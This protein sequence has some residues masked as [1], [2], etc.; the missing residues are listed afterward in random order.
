MPAITLDQIKAATNDELL[1]LVDRRH[2]QYAEMKD[3]WTFLEETYRGGREWFE[4][5]LWKYR[6]EGA[7]EFR[8][9][10]KRAYRYPHTREV[11][12]LVNK[13]VLKGD[14]VRSTEAPDELKRFWKSATLMRRPVATLMDTISRKASTFG[15]IYI[16]VDNNFPAGIATKAEQAASRGRVYSYVISPLDALDFAF[17]EDGKLSWFLN[18]E[19]HRDDASPLTGGDTTVRYRLWAPDFWATIEV[20]GGQGQ[21]RKAFI[22]KS[23]ENELGE[24]PIIIHDHNPSE[25][26]YSSPALIEDTAYLDRAAANYLS[27]LDAIIQDQTFS[28]LVIPHQGLLED[29]N[30]ETGKPSTVKQLIAMGTKRVFAYNAEG[31]AAPSF[32]SPDVKQAD[33]IMAAISKIIDEIYHSIGMA[34]ERT[35]QDN[36]VGIDNSSGVAKA[37][38]FERLNAMLVAKALGLALAENEISRLVMGWNGT[39]KAVED[40][41]EYVSYPATF[42]VRNLADEMDNSQK[43]AVMGAPTELRRL[44]MKKLVEKMYPQLPAAD[45]EKIVEDIEDTWLELVPTTMVEEGAR[46]A[47]PKP[48]RLPGQ[49]GSQGQNNKGSVKADDKAAVVK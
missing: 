37:Y 28:Q 24:I 3:H 44:Q 41:E 5:N 19:V 14:I 8:D 29:G 49:K 47:A 22:A 38:D 6:K 45:R 31:G 15:R 33:L 16:V 40:A 27:C 32:I 23:G 36:S 46:P 1:K 35:K 4:R 34:G 17:D 20:S 48:G 42:D 43:L 10:K 12:N 39:R 25:E 7:G 13:Y 18:S 26:L 2:P 30:E 9:R 21:T 11:V